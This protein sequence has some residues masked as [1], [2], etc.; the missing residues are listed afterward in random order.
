MGIIVRVRMFLGSS[1]MSQPIS[2]DGGVGEVVPEKRITP[3]KERSV[4]MAV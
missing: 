2:Q 4:S 3:S 1:S